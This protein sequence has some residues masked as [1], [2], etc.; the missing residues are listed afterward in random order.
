[1]LR[2]FRACAFRFALTP[3][4]GANVLSF[5]YEKSQWRHDIVVA[6]V[7]T[8]IGGILGILGTLL[9]VILG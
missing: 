5:A 3:S 8:A 4:H 1:M 9:G 2:V 7:S 6:S